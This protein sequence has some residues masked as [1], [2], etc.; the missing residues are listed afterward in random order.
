[1]KAKK[2]L[3]V[4]GGACGYDTVLTDVVS[5]IGTARSAAVRS[6]NAVMTAT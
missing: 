4:R 3:I 2:G 5:L 6:V 1:M